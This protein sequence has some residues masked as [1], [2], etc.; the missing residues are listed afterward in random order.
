MEPGQEGRSEPIEPQTMP[1]PDPRPPDEIPALA[2]LLEELAERGVRYCSW[3]SNDHL[4]E[5][6]AGRTDLDL[7]VARDDAVEFREVVARHGGK[8]LVPQPYAAYPGMEH[9]L[10]VDRGS[11]RLFHLHVHSRLVLGERYVKN[12]HLPLEGRTFASLRML[13]GVPIPSADVELAIL[14]VRALLKYRAR[15]VVK[16]VLGIRTPGIPEETL[17]EI[18]WLLSQTTASDVVA[19]FE[20]DPGGIDEATITAFLDVIRHRPRSGWALLRLRGQVRRS[21]RGSQRSGRIHVTSSYLATVWRRRTRWRWRQVETG[22]KPA[23]GGFGVAFVGADGA[24]KSTLVEAVAGWLAWKLVVRSYYLGS[25]Q[26]SRMSR[27]SYTAFRACRRATRSIEARLT[28]RTIMA[29]PTAYARDVFLASHHLAVAHDRLRRLEAARRDVS[30]GR[31]VIFDRFPME[32]LGADPDHRLLDGPQIPSALPSPGSRLVRSL[33]AREAR[34]YGRFELPDELVVLRVSPDVSIA[35]KP[36]HDHMTVTRKGRAVLQ[37][38]RA[39]EAVMG[40]TVT[41]IDADRPFDEVLRRV[42]GRVWDAI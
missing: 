6:L 19:V 9:F 41:V 7:L 30:A 8:P 34:I 12:H 21:L 18:G 38:A 24:G 1:G 13:E 32:R 36:D 14:C 2:A 20:G 42:Q 15:D 39:A 4:L 31:V 22:M 3:K 40:S 5:G 35:R 29:R 28:P 16:D 27:W 17:R 10:G 33:A 26:P 25:K 11:G 37:L 23:G